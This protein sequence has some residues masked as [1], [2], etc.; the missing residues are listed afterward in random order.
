M[1]ATC[2]NHLGFD[3]WGAVENLYA[4]LNNNTL[5]CQKLLSS[6]QKLIVTKIIPT[7]QPVLVN[8][9][10]EPRAEGTLW[11]AIH[12]NM[13]W[14]CIDSPNYLSFASMQHSGCSRAVSYFVQLT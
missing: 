5:P 8:C 3:V 1:D 14:S 13:A 11:W 12:V 6:K 2:I 10:N 7:H 4:M 9:S